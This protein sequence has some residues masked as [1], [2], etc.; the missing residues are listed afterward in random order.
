MK[1]LFSDTELRAL[2]QREEGQFLEFKSL[3]NRDT[4]SRKVLDRRKVR[5][6]IADILDHYTL[7]DFAAGHRKG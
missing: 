2:L 4:T 1:V 7:D 3:W 5:D 6:A